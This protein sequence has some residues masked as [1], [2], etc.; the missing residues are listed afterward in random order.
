MAGLSA[1]P[2]EVDGPLYRKQPACG[3]ASRAAERVELLI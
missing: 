2:N 1:R 3:S